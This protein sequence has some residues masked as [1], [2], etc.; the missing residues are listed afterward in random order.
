MVEITVE[1]KRYNCSLKIKEK[2]T[3]IKGD[4]GVGKTEFTRR[5]SSE[6]NA[7]KISVSNGYDLVVLRPDTFRQICQRAA[8]DAT[9]EKR[10]HA[11]ESYWSN[12][13]NFPYYN[14]I[15]IVDDE[16]FVKSRDFSY[17]FN[18]DKYNYY[19][20]ISRSKVPGINYSV[21]EVYNFVKDGKNHYTKKAY[22]YPS[23][24]KIAT[25]L[26]YVMTEGKGSDFIFFN[27]MLNGK[28]VNSAMFGNAD[29]GGKNNLVNRLA[30]NSQ[31][32]SKTVFLLID[33]CAF[34][35]DIDDLQNACS[36]NNVK[37]Y[38]NKDYLSF[39]YLLLISKMIDDTGLEDFVENSRLKYQSLER[40]FTSR[41][42]DLTK[43]TLYNY[44]KSSEKCSVCYYE[45]CC[46]NKRN[47]KGDCE[48]RR[49]FLDKDKIGKMLKD[50]KFEILLKLREQI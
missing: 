8:G 15:I 35:N 21:D 17:F 1:S 20:I 41:L 10:G 13:D 36:V 33:F 5:I 49:L 16:D 25:K 9:G 22:S 29:S 27:A 38:F 42:S 32:R 11:L 18:C 4:S 3:F 47:T 37:V 43:D 31:F 19:I 46:S 40:L 45:V 34:G 7:N 24:N 2:V 44:S 50:T 39:E 6:S 30:L 48:K 26:D 12:R 14:S 23:V 28:A